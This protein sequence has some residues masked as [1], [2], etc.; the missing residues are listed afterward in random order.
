MNRRRMR[1]S[2]RSWAPWTVLVGFLAVP[3][4]VYGA[5]WLVA[6]ADNPTAEAEPVKPII[7]PVAF[8]DTAARANV[9]VAVQPSDGRQV[10]TRSSGTVTS[11]PRPG[12]SLHQ[13]DVAMEVDDM[14]IRAFI[15]SAP[16]WR[17]LSVGD[18]GPDVGRLEAYLAD[19][20]YYDGAIDDVFGKGLRAAVARFNADAGKEKAYAFDP[21]TV[22][23]VGEERL[24]VAES[25]VD[26]GDVVGPGSPVMQAP[27]G[28][29]SVSVG[30]PQGGIAALGDFGDNAE[31][32]VGSARVPY[33]PGSGLV[34]DPTSVELIAAALAPATDGVATITA[35]QSRHVAVVPASALVQGP[36]GTLCVY[37]SPDADP[38]SVTPWGGGVASA[39][40]PSDVGLT[41]VLTNPGRVALTHS[42]G[43]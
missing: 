15:A 34:T 39:E 10:F 26:V 19:L 6:N 37:S 28:V 29:A 36:N 4:F 20:G 31:L 25:L 38:V 43:S 22:V 5:W 13:G 41:Q 1:Q 27:S 16:L 12:A 9:S 40:L 8:E 7:V 33:T 23:W 14:P 42:C 18:T 35:T 11:A 24:V 30:E 2:A 32:A 21:A 17:S 3:V